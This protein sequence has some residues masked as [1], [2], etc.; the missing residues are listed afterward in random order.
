MVGESGVWARDVAGRAEVSPGPPGT[1]GLLAG[2]A[3]CRC[4]LSPQAHLP[5]TR[6]SRVHPLLSGPTFPPGGF[7]HV[8]V[9]GHWGC[10]S[11]SSLEGLK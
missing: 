1:R 11:Q 7:S 3:L 8:R 2:E 4:I 6:L 5:P 10:S 9:G